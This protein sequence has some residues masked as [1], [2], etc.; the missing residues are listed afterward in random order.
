V[1]WAHQDHLTGSELLPY[2]GVSHHRYQIRG[3]VAH[4]SAFISLALASQAQNT[5]YLPARKPALF[6]GPMQELPEQ[7]TIPPMKGAINDQTYPSPPKAALGPSPVPHPL[8]SAHNGWA[9]SNHSR[10]E[11]PVHATDT[12]RTVYVIG[13][14]A[15]AAPTVPAAYTLTRIGW[16]EGSSKS[17]GTPREAQTQRNIDPTSIFVGGLDV[18]GQNPWS[19]ERVK[20]YFSRFGGLESVKFVKPCR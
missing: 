20:D 7:P 4:P 2:P 16:V 5:G 1:T 3:P 14:R 12:S 18:V 9:L 15:L 17:P 8:R 6:V 13:N 10:Y 19:E 11:I